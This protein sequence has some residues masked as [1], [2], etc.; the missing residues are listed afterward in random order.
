MGGGLLIKN[1]F[2]FILLITFSICANSNQYTEQELEQL[3]A[4]AMEK[5]RLLMMN[6]ILDVA[7][8][9]QNSN[10]RSREEL[11]ENLCSTAPMNNFTVNADIS[12]SLTQTA[13]DFSG[14]IFVSRD[15]QASWFS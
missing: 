15:N 7:R 14:S 6:T 10:L 13:G 4:R 9:V 12:D 5:A 1:L 3:K 2:L 11:I 8:D